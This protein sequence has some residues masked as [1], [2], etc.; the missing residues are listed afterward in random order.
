MKSQKNDKNKSIDKSEE[1]K[2]YV[3]V[4]RMLQL[5]A[6]GCNKVIEL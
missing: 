2:Q 5:S 4:E 1:T 6:I 3:Q